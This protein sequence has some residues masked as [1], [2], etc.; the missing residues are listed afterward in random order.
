MKEKVKWDVGMVF[1]RVERWKDISVGGGVIMKEWR[2]GYMG[3][4]RRVWGG[5]GVWKLF[6]Y[7]DVEIGQEGARL[8]EWQVCGPINKTLSRQMANWRVAW[9]WDKLTQS[10]L[11][12]WTGI[13]EC[14]CALACLW[15]IQKMNSQISAHMHGERVRNGNG[16][17]EKKSE[18]EG[19]CV[20]LRMSAETIT[21]NLSAQGP[22]FSSF[23]LVSLTHSLPISVSHTHASLQ[24]RINFS[25]SIWL[26]PLALL[27]SPLSAFSHFSATFLSS[28]I[29]LL[30]LS[31]S[32][33]SDLFCCRCCLRAFG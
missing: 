28:C 20:W 19:V 12:R 5:G 17:W 25:V 31:V 9:H 24:L 33:P 14:V 11:R 6:S 22:I 7:G 10:D 30:T 26:V 29:F 15:H 4:G 16:K 2:Q 32:S 13:W 23:V 21:L 1:R 27:S 8:E 18:R 3:G